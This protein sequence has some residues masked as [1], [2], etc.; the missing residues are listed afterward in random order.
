MS[1][2][3]DGERG[4]RA[5]S[6][7]RDE[8][9]NILVLFAILLPVFMVCAAIVIDVGY[10]WAN[11]RKAQIA[12]DA[13]ALAAAREL[14]QSAASG[15]W[16]RSDCA[17][18]GVDYVVTNIPDQSPG[19]EPVHLSTRV[20]WPY[21]GDMTLVEATVDMS[22]R[23]F[24][25]RFVGLGNV[26]LT[27]RAVA[28][29]SEGEGDYAIY[30]HAPGC[31][32]AL[33]F[34]GGSIN[35]NGRAHSNGEYTVD[36]SSFWAAEG[37]FNSPAGSDGGCAADIEPGSLFGDSGTAPTDTGRQTWPDWYTP[38]QF[39]W[40]AG[41]TYRGQKIEIDS[42]TLK[43][44]GRPDVNHGGTLP[45]GVYCATELVN[46]SANGLRGTV[47][48]LAPKIEVGGNDNDFTAFAGAHSN[49]A[50]K[51]LFFSVPNIDTSTTNDGAP[52]GSG[53]LTCDSNVVKEMKL[54]NGNNSA[55][56]GIVFHPC[57]KVIV[58]G[59]GNMSL[60]GAIYANQVLIN[61]NGF[62]MV[63]RGRNG[64]NVL[65]ALDQ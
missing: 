38:D 48:M 40:W 37:T 24:F 25:G 52:D 3:R 57:G 26:D 8:S 33:R 22:V 12:A 11:G 51:V 16:N 1:A 47:T 36:G 56:R 17:F 44:T 32:D 39:G 59:N 29:R 60:E 30:A 9:G 27:R 7:C 34:N 13:C 63:G 61:G 54:L 41:C 43:I 20:V 62:N 64:A 55:W 49:P 4:Q 35:I 45:S 23:T 19:S 28:E 42:T 31:G 65:L 15:G 21:E 58:D 10:W 14:P 5:G 46:I 2:H 50:R 6:R 18:G 53:S